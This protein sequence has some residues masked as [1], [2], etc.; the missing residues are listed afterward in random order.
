M[1]KNTISGSQMD[2]FLR[3]RRAWYYRYDQRLRPEVSSLS[4][5][6]GSAVHELIA[7]KPWDQVVEGK[8]FEELD[9][10]I[11]T[12]L[13]N[14]YVAKWGSAMPINF[15]PEIELAVTIDGS[16]KFNF[17]SIL[18][19]LGTLPD[20][21][22]C[23]CEHKTCG[24]DISDSGS[25]WEGTQMNV[26]LAGQVEAAR[27]HGYNVECIVYDVIRKPSIRPKQIKVA[28][29]NRIETAEEFGN[30]LTADIAERPE[31]YYAR[32][33]I[34]VL[35]SDIAEFQ[36]ARLA[37]CWEIMAA[38][39]MAG[40]CKDRA[41]AYPRSSDRRG[42][43]SYCENRGFCLAGITVDDNNVPSGFR[44]E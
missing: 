9:L 27:T 20:G 15:F 8:S 30:R 10:A 19:A 13:F 37:V 11:L 24:E 44:R 35:D 34:P 2:T 36:A 41:H 43:C 33:E 12:A 31:F 6:F 1:I 3:C 21:R 4:L 32:K 28:G 23:I 16:R 42:I 38:A 14:G 29:I 17:V 22:I 40:K 5:R 39:K 7:G 26:Q 18:D 25:Y